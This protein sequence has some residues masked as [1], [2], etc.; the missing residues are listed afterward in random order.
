MWFEFWS[1]DFR[2]VYS[3]VSLSFLTWQPQRD[4]LNF[5]FW[6]SI[7]KLEVL[8]LGFLTEGYAYGVKASV[9]DA[10]PLLKAL[11]ERVGNHPRVKE[12]NDAHPGV[13]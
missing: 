10:C 3:K 6:V 2:L 4:R 8:G 5:G 12:W 7:A 11:V 1:V 13:A 9:M